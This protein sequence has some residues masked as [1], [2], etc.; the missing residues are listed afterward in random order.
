M[1]LMTVSSLSPGVGSKAG[2]LSACPE[3]NRS[4]VWSWISKPFDLSTSQMETS[5]R[6]GLRISS[7]GRASIKRTELVGTMLRRIRQRPVP[8][9]VRK[10]RRCESGGGGGG[11]PTGGG[12]FFMKCSRARVSWL[13]TSSE[14]DGAE[15]RNSAGN[16][17]CLRTRKN[18]VLFIF[19]ISVSCFNCSSSR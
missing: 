13:R 14:Q 18:G 16:N 8:M 12:Q 4:P 2:A 9:S 15:M 19:I 17:D 7:A 10:S 1:V 5:H 3:S 6:N 11:G